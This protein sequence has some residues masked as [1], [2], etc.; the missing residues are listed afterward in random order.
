MSDGLGWDDLEVALAGPGVEIRTVE[1]AGMTNALIRLSAGF[2]ARPV[3]KGLPGDL[4]QVP[5]WGYVIAGRLTRADSDRVLAT[6]RVLLN[7]RS[8]IERLLGELGTGAIA[9]DA[10]IKQLRE[11]LSGPAL[12]R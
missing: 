10:A 6:V 3:F 1:A 7:D 5:H 9:A 11:V 8:Q 12:R 4:C 2:D